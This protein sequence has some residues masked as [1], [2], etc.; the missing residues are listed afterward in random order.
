VRLDIALNGQDFKGEKS[1]TFTQEIF[2][3]R[4]V[5]M[6]G[7]VE[8]YTK[9]TLI[10]TGF[11]TLNNPVNSKWGIVSTDKILKAEVHDYVY[12]KS[13]FENWQEG[14]EGIK[15]YFFEAS[16]LSRVDS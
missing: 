4:I 6:A 16:H 11:R 10:G 3:H 1:F 12:Q 8:G 9:S 14:F 2:L 15:G 5:P 7:P 13:K